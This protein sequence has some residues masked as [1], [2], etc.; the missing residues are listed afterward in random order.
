MK[1]SLNAKSTKH[2]SYAILLISVLYVV[3]T[4]I[5]IVTANLNVI[6]IMELLTIIAAVLIVRLM[7]EFHR[8]SSASKKAQSLMA[9]VLA[10]CMAA[11]TVMNH[12]LCL[13]VLN[14]LFSNREIPSWLLLYGWPS[15]T[16]AL[17]CVSW[18]LFLGLSMLYASFALEELESIAITWTMRICGLM[19]LAGLSGPFTG[20]MNLYILSTVGYSVGFLLISIELILFLKKR[21][22]Q[23]VK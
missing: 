11:I 22:N 23:E 19:T 12:F 10:T 7:A 4:S 13:T 2:I 17:E 18:G 1:E 14:P 16:K 20:N 6:V 9:I 15:L 5:W 3:F 8:A 21:V